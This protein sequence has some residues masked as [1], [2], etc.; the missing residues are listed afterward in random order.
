[1][2]R[3]TGARASTASSS[4]RATESATGS[5][6]AI[7]IDEHPGG[8]RAGRVVDYM[9]V[10]MEGTEASRVRRRR[11]WPAR[12]R[13][14]RVEAHP[15]FGLSRRATASSSSRVSG[16]GP[17]PRRRSRTSGSTR[18]ATSCWTRPARSRRAR[19]PRS[20]PPSSSARR[21]VAGPAGRARPVVRRVLEEDR[22]RV[23]PRAPPGRGGGTTSPVS[24]ISSAESPQSVA[25]KGVPQAI[26]SPM[27]SGIAS[28]EAEESTPTSAAWK[29]RWTSFRGPSRRARSPSGSAS[30]ASSGSSAVT[31]VPQST[32]WTSASRSETIPAALSRLAWSFI[33][34]RRAAWATT[35]ASGP[36]PS[37]E[38]RAAP[39]TGSGATLSVSKPLGTT[40]A[41]DSS[42]PEA[43]HQVVGAVGAGD[44]PLRD[45]VGEAALR[46]PAAPPE[47]GR[48]FRPRPRSCA[49][50]SRRERAG[51]GGRGT[52]ART[53]A[54]RSQVW[55]ISGREAASVR[56]SLRTPRSP[57]TSRKVHGDK[58][59]A[60]GL[61]PL[62][63]RPRAR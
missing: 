9:H 40:E 7:T 13:S 60:G 5:V 12:V 23:P 27:T 35:S 45:P 42:Y 48:G 8:L 19:S 20:S 4:A 54:C 21:S 53:F 22:A 41:P 55:T 29:M 32:K 18:F 6:P 31:P 62:A 11:D 2:D 49:S 17:G 36:I 25:T 3:E 24:P 43:S 51:A 63:E 46:A 1:M 30:A 58:R 52:P 44:D 38:R 57:G 28:P 39:A 33:G 59:I 26:A 10:S 61:D 37:S 34:W 56:P 15:Y 50:T 14:L 47:S 16:F